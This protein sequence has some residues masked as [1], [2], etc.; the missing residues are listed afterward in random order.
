MQHLK[1]KAIRILVVDDLILNQEIARVFI[2]DLGFC[3]DVADDGAKAVE[4]I[5][6]KTYSL[7]FMD[8]QCL[9]SPA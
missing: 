5:K 8:V 3:I 4:A 2:E 1:R 7:V 6:Q 9:S